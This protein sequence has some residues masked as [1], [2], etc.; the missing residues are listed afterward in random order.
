MRKYM[1]IV[2]FFLSLVPIIIC[3]NYRKN[4]YLTGAYLFLYVFL[5][6]QAFQSVVLVAQYLVIK[7]SLKR[8]LIYLELVIFI[9]LCLF[10]LIYIFKYN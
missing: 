1:P 7:E 6:A 8:M 5:P 9:G 3:L 2:L 10:A 4:D